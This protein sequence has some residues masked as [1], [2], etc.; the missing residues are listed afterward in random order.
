MKLGSDLLAAPVS[1]LGQVISNL[2]GWII[3]L[4]AGLATLYLVIGFT[5][6][7][8][9]GGDPAQAESAKGSLK[10][11]AIGYAGA[12]LAPVLMTALRSILGL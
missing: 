3:G 11:A 10:A 5:K 8:T 12:I 1:D 4:L 2:Q 7:L 6:Y 9:A